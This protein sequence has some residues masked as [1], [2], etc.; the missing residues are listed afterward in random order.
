MK[1]SEE[2][3]KWAGLNKT[4]AAEMSKYSKRVDFIKEHLNPMPDLDGL[5]AMVSGAKG[6]EDKLHGWEQVAAAWENCEGKLNSKYAAV[7]ERINK[8]GIPDFIK[9]IVDQHYHIVFNQDSAIKLRSDGIFLENIATLLAS[10]SSFLSAQLTD[11]VN[12]SMVFSLETEPSK[13]NDLSMLGYQPIDY[14][15]FNAAITD[16]PNQDYA[17]IAPRFI[18]AASVSG[19]NW[20]ELMGHM[21]CVGDYVPLEKALGEIKGQTE[22]CADIL[23]A[24]DLSGVQGL[25]VLLSENEK[26]SEYVT[27]KDKVMRVDFFRDSDAGKI[28]LSNSLLFKYDEKRLMIHE[29]AD[30]LDCVAESYRQ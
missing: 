6:F 9:G 21:D 27:S 24:V 23:K 8:G 19:Y 5:K 14:L 12:G 16:F 22:N 29:I 1:V 30:I 2:I 15:A 10:R 28:K 20:F 25:F 3:I 18:K 4:L 11:Y 26:I 17:T 13:D 7:Y